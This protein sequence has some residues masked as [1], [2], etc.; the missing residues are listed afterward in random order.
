M[1]LLMQPIHMTIRKK[2]YWESRSAKGEELFFQCATGGNVSSLR[3]VVSVSRKV[4]R[5]TLQPGAFIKIYC[6]AEKNGALSSRVH[7]AKCSSFPYFS[8][9]RRMRTRTQST[10][11]YASAD[12]NTCTE[13]FA[14]KRWKF[15]VDLHLTC[16]LQFWSTY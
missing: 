4:S 6:V 2:K 16:G 1:R 15:Q 12:A 11:S 7:K 5:D 8:N 13:T 3:N 9:A 14:S 10:R